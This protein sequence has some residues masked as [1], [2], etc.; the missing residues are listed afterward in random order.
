M[1][2]LELLTEQYQLQIQLNEL[3]AKAGEIQTRL[4]EIQATLKDRINEKIH[5]SS[6]AS[7]S[8]HNG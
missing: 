4:N 6:F 5:S 1:T 3:G 8:Q 7:D 2:E